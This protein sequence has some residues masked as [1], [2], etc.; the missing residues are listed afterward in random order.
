[1]VERRLTGEPLAWITGH[2]QFCGLRIRVDPG[3]Y[4]PR[5]QTQAL[6]QR[7]VACLPPKGTAID[8]CTGAGAI[9]KVLST[10]HPGARIVASDIDGRAIVCALSN[11]VEAVRGDLFTPLPRSL[12][13]AV[14]VVV[15]VVPYVPTPALS[16]LQRDALSFESTSSYDGGPDGTDV[17]R[18]VLHESP[19][20][21]RP[22]G[23]ILLE[24]GGEQAELLR[25]DLA[26]LGYDDVIEL[27]DDEGDLRGIEATL[28]SASTT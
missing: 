15:G 28:R 7:A 18:R 10:A 19:R 20:F 4:V 14:D 26:R 12:E 2:V 16:L 5:W 25:D 9:A 17:L 21:L 6:A 1:M 13:G 22:A 24:L 27:F 8:V 3:V 23:V 11:G